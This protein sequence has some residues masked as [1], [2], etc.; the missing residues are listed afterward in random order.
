[1]FILRKVLKNNVVD[2]KIIGEN[3]Q[4]VTKIHA[5]EAF[6]ELVKSE[7]YFEGEKEKIFAILVY[8][9]GSE[10]LALFEDYTYY[11]MLNNSTTFEKISKK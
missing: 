8:N 6:D 4:L 7:P 5:K 1:M 11:M 3:Y 9:S 2:N 10:T